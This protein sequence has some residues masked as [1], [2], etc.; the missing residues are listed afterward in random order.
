MHLAHHSKQEGCNILRNG[1][2]TSGIQIY[3]VIEDNA[4]GYTWAQKT[5]R[6]KANSFYGYIGY[7]FKC[8]FRSSTYFLFRLWWESDLE[9]DN[10]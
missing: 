2:Q 8:I 6:D 5:Y 3:I 9:D 1:L 7:I 10:F 4:S